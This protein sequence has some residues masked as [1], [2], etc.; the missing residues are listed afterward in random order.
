MARKQHAITPGL[1]SGAYFSGSPFRARPPRNCN[2]PLRCPFVMCV[3]HALVFWSCAVCAKSLVNSCTRTRRHTHAH[4][5]VCVC[6]HNSRTAVRTVHARV[7][8]RWRSTCTKLV[9]AAYSPRSSVQLRGQ[10]NQCTRAFC[11]YETHNTHTH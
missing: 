2:I 11:T 9:I 4:M 7:S 6:T 3:W 8:V 1:A 5:C 10:R